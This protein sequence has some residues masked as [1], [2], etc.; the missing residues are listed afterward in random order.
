MGIITEDGLSDK[1]AQIAE[2]L[3]REFEVFKIEEGLVRSM[4]VSEERY[5][6]GLAIGSALVEEK[7]AESKA[8]GIA[9]VARNMLKRGKPI[10]EIIE[11]TGLTYEEVKN[12]QDAEENIL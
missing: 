1:L 4:T 12:L 8:E 10:D 6:E 3:K 11:D 9:A 5:E 2:M 7:M